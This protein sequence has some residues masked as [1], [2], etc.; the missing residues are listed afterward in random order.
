MTISKKLGSKGAV[1][2][3]QQLRHAAGIMPGAPLDI[4]D[5]GDGLIIRKHV[6]SCSF[7]GS[8]ENVVKVEDIEICACCAKKLAAAAAEKLEVT[9]NG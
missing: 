5:A 8:V 9:D 6:P 7:C 3:P 4:E 2:I 1:T